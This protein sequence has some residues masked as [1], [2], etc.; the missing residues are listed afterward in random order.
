MLLIGHNKVL[1]SQRLSPPIEGGWLTRPL[2]GKMPREGRR[3]LTIAD[4]LK[5]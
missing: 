3:A 2:I 4:A 5:S 1:I